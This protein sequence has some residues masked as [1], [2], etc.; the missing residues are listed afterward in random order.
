MKALVIF[1]ALAFVFSETIA[2]F[3]TTHNLQIRK[4]N[5][6]I[7]VD[8]VMDE[9]DWALSDIADNF[10]KISLQTHRSPKPKLKCASSSMKPTF[11]LPL[12]ATTNCRV[13]T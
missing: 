6:K 11:T 13:I 4:A 12:F 1:I 8:G 7:T 9:P 5:G 10:T 3:S 2:Q